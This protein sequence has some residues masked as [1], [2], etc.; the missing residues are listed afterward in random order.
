MAD[1]KKPQI[2]FDLRSLEIFS[3]VVELKSFSKAAESVRLAQ[4]SVSER[5]ATLEGAIGAKLLDRLGRNIVPTKLGQLLYDRAQRHLEL[6]RQTCLEMQE[7]LGTSRGDITMGGSTIPGEYI[8]PGII[9]R[10]K[11]SY[12]DVVVRMSIGDSDEIARRVHNGELELGII[13]SRSRHKELKHIELWKDELVVVI[14][15]THHW[16]NRKSV[17]IEDLYREPFVSREAGSG[18]RRMIEHGLRKSRVPDLDKLQIVA[19]LGSSTA[20]KQALLKGLGISILSNRAVSTEVQSGMLR[21][22]PVQ[23]LSLSRRFYLV[24]D[25]RRSQ[26]PLCKIFEEFL[27]TDKSAV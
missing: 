1:R 4:A 14:P 24:K 2:D 11:E 15:A 21:T 16:K 23:G 17:K 26:S 19:Q 8:L 5:I 20:V 25:R 10:F 9:T 27:I 6:K 7:F 12:P 18:T 3:R 22:L 13:G